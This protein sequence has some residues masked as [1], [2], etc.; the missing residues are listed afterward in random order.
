M[1]RVGTLKEIWRFP[2][3]SMQ[4]DTVPRAEVTRQGLLGDRAW[5]MRDEVRQEVQWGKMYPALM[6][7]KARYRDEPKAGGANVVDIRFPD[8][9][10]VGSDDPR[11]DAKLTALIGRAARLWPLQPASHLDFYKRYK[12]DEEKFAQ[13]MAAL[14]AREGDEPLPDFATFP[15]V[16]MEYVAVPG[17]FFDN[18]EINLMTTASLAHMKSRN[19]AAD[20][21]V[22]RF[23]PNFLI[24]TAPGIEGLAETAWVGR[25][26][27]IGGLLLELT[28]ATPRCGMT[29]QPQDGL[30]YDKTILR[31]IVR[32]GA[33]CLG[34]G[35]HC[36]EAGAVTAGDAVELLD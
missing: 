4:G 18:E 9:E 26:L 13:E 1:N 8:G 36:L 19:P 15:E 10:S 29:V 28:M 30:D 35:A 20:W 27:R 23:R 33:Q 17:T 21:D 2:V 22:R 11:V 34:V 16:L 24:E 12:P 31:T 6:L 3:K 25:R 5:A 7:C 32:E 14:F